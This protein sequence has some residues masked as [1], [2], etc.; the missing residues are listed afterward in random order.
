[1]YPMGHC[2]WHDSHFGVFCIDSG[3]KSM[4]SGFDLFLGEWQSGPSR[5]SKLPLDQIRTCD[6]LRDWMLHLQTCVHLHEIELL[7]GVHD[8]FHCPRPH[9]AHSLSSTNSSC[10][11]PLSGIRMKVRLRGGERG[12]LFNRATT[13][14]NI[15]SQPYCV[16]VGVA[17]DRGVASGCGYQCD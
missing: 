16:W 2:E 9:I 3:F 1:M 13:T 17:R 12:T 15:V 14:D 4:S 5:H 10:T 8:E 7:S 6:H 11:D